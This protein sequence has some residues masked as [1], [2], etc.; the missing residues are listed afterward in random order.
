MKKGRKMPVKQTLRRRKPL[1]AG[2]DRPCTPHM[3]FND[4]G[5]GLKIVPPPHTLAK[6]TAPIEYL[7]DT[8]VDCFCWCLANGNA[9]YD[10]KVM[11][12]IYGLYDKRKALPGAFRDMSRTDLANTLE[13][14]HAA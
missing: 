2:S 8:P 10:S 13:A 3:I 11:E 4:D 14:G 7:K 12:T 6:V 1:R 5:D 9:S